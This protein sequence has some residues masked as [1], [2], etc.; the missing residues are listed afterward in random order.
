MG[1]FARFDG[2][3]QVVFAR[4][5]ER[6][7]TCIVA[8]HSTRLG[9]ALGGTRWR[10]YATEEDALEDV[11]R[12]SRAM[13]LKNACAGIDHGGGKAV[14]VGDPA[15]DRSEALLRAYGRVIASLGGRYVTACDIGTTPADMAII[16]RETP[17]A[18]GADADH[19]GSGDSGV[20]T[21]FGVEL[22]MKAACRFTFGSD[23]LAGRH[24]AVQGLGK[25]GGRLV[26]SLADQGAKLTVADI[27]EAAL[28]R[29]TDLPGVDV[30]GVDEVLFA[31]ADVVS[32]NALGAV[33]DEG[34]I[35]QLQARIV[36][37]GANN[38]LAG[39]EDADRLRDARILYCPDFVVNAGGVIQVADEL[40][41]GGYLPGRARKRAETIPGTLTAIL[42]VARDEDVTTEVAAERVAE[43][44]IAAV[45]GLRGFHLP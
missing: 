1:P 22:A 23:D 8:I 7:L 34:S 32:P 42:E 3:E 45:G 19:G 27:S 39:D 29:V 15:V 18:T 28:D 21:S 25:V 24:I 37:G 10:P 44:R 9:P 35:P 6:G 17:W 26:A 16:K 5:E 36:C 20:T 30:V 4:D 2:H 14:I 13:T 11:L 40:Q 41:P 31:D 43:R 33:L 38:Q 12:L